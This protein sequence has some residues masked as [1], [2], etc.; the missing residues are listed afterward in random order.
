MCAQKYLNI[1]SVLSL[2]REKEKVLSTGNINYSK[3]D[4]AFYAFWIKEN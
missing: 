4:E 3:S 2:Q 1:F